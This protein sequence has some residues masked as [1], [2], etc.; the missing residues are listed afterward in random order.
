MHVA[1]EIYS[2]STH[3]VHGAK[4]TVMEMVGVPTERQINLY[5]N[6]ISMLEIMLMIICEFHNADSI[7]NR[8]DNLQC[9]CHR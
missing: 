3:S 6:H 4:T 1:R 7:M 9:T 8:L 5:E 2:S